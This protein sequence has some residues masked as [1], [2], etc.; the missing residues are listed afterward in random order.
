MPAGGLLS[1]PES[2]QFGLMY[3]YDLKG[4]VV[5]SPPTAS[6]TPPLIVFLL[7]LLIS[8][9]IIFSPARLSQYNPSS[10]HTLVILLCTEHTPN[11]PC[12]LVQMSSDVF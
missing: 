12:A 6:Y 10:Q 11:A 3:K 2:D 1:E 7:F 4:A 5:R 9:G 8:F